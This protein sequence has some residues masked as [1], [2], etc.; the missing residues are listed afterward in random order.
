MRRDLRI[1][2]A[3]AVGLGLGVSVALQATSGH[4][5][6]YQPA[7]SISTTD[8]DQA[9]PANEYSPKNHF[10]V[11]FRARSAASY[12]HMYVMY[13][14]ANK[15]HE[16]IRSQIAGF[17]PAGDAQDCI[18]CSVYNW[19]LG[20]ILPVPSE[21]GV[22]DGDLEEQYVLARY[23]AWIDQAQYERL[24]AYIE[25]RKATKGPWNAFL[26]NCVTFGRDVAVF[27][28]LNVPP[29]YSIAPSVLL[30]PQD[31]VEMLR[32]ANG[33][34][35]DEGPLKDAPGALP[36]EIAAEFRAANPSSAKSG[37]A[38]KYKVHA[39]AEEKTFVSAASLEHRTANAGLQDDGKSD[40][41]H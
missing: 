26:N 8:P 37:T 40:S 14:E 2:V 39:A 15:R 5:Q 38:K 22:T 35:K 23:R 41:V 29:L 3:V 4:A 9:K 6:D 17:F 18:N 33:G 21:I 10:F 20:H 16:V 32:D 11:E 28:G 27:V 7:A 34:E 12:G 13:G 25:N 31:V 36:P 19:T 24:V 1:S 30:Y